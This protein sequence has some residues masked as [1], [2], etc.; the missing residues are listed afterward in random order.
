[1]VPNLVE[2]CHDSAK[3]TNFKEINLRNDI[4]LSFPS[5][6]AIGIAVQNNR[7]SSDQVVVKT[8]IKIDS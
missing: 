8:T 6:L 1:M 3:D 5:P 2:N 7:S 4:L